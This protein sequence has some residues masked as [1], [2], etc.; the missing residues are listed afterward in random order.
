MER[1]DNSKFFKSKFRN[2]FEFSFQL[3]LLVFSHCL[4]QPTVNFCGILDI[5]WSSLFCILAQ[6]LTY[7]ITLIQLDYVNLI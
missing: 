7:I 3:E 6:T 4:H 5:N 2:I 1:V